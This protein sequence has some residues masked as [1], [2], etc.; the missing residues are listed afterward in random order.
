MNSAAGI[1]VKLFICQEISYH[2]I[3]CLHFTYAAVDDLKEI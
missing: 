3:S 1:I 2:H